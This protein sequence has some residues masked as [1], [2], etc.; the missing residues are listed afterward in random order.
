[1]HFNSDYKVN[2]IVKKKFLV[3]LGVILP[4]LKDKNNAA[5]QGLE[6]IIHKSWVMTTSMYWQYRNREDD[7]RE[8]R[9]AERGWDVCHY[10]GP[11]S[12]TR[13]H[14]PVTPIFTVAFNIYFFF[15][16]L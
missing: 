12:P 4:K 7:K 6:V 13:G 16:L 1:M 8:D 11:K 5:A 2:D 10:E 14:C 9:A 3:I 15:N